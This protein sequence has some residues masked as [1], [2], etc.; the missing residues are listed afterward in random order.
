VVRNIKTKK[1]VEVKGMT[2]PKIILRDGREYY[3]TETETHH[4]LRSAEK[5]KRGLHSVIRF[6]K[7]KELHDKTVEFIHDFIASELL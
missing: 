4:I 7:N 3:L 1:I 2:K 5:S 6:T